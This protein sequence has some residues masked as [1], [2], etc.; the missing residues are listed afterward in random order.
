M[1]HKVTT[2][3]LTILILAVAGLY[4]L[5]FSRNNQSS[6]HPK[7]EK[8]IVSH[9]PDSSVRLAY[10]DL[11]TIKEKYEY[12]K[13]KNTELEREKQRIENEVEAGVQKLE[14]DRNNFLK[15]GQSITQ[16]EAEQF[17]MEFQ[18]RYQALGEKREKLLNQHLSN[19]AKAM[20]DIQARINA[21][22]KDYNKTAGYHF[23]FSTGEGNLTLYYTDDAF[24]I[25]SEV[26]E[27]LNDIY[28]KEKNK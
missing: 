4:Y 13:L 16:Q 24:N 10:I 15:K 9:S 23:I 14:A 21:Y 26:I 17:Q 11:D 5:H 2:A 18:T 28:Q 3:L 1:Q 12:F 25:T 27:G 19:Q 6:K 22:L 20:D 8:K 7:I